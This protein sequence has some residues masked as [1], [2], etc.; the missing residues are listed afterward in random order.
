M[1]ILTEDVHNPVLAYGVGA[2]ATAFDKGY[3]Y[4][5]VVGAQI[6]KLPRLHFAM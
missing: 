6:L 2:V 3:L 4:L 5:V 1:L